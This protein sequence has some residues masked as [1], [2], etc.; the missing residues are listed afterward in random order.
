MRKIAAVLLCLAWPFGLQAEGSFRHQGQWLA[1]IP[2][3]P[4]YSGT[5]LVDGEGR[6]TWEAAWD[7]MKWN[8]SRGYV[9]VDGSMVEF[10]VTDGTH[11]ANRARCTV[12]S[13]NLLHCYNTL[14]NGKTSDAIFLTRIGPGPATLLSGHE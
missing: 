10:I 9:R 11:N 7:P 8:K 4:S 2:A 5:V 12:Q 13:K 6:V 3:V 1:V 14:S